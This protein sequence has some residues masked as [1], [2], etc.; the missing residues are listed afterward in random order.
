M[1]S[2][3]IIK[4]ELINQKNLLEQKGFVVEVQ[5]NNPSPTEI[6]TAINN[7]EADFTKANA[8][9]EDVMSGKTFFAQTGELK[10]GTL[11]MSQGQGSNDLALAMITSVGSQEIIIPED[12]KYTAIR[13]YAYHAQTAL[14][15]NLFYKHNLTIPNNITTIGASCFNSCKLTGKVTVPASVTKIGM[16]AFRYC[17]MEEVELS[18]ENLTS[19]TYVCSHNPNL[20]KAV[21]NA[22]IPQL[23]SYSFAEC[24]SL[25][26]VHLPSTLT[27]ISS[28]A[29][30]KCSGL[31]FIKFNNPTPCV[32][33][34]NLFH[35]A[36]NVVF[37]VPY[38]SYDSYLNATNFQYLERAQYGFGEFLAGTTF[39]TSITGYS[40]T[41]H[42]SL[43]EAKDATNPITVCQSNGTYYA[44]FTATK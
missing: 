40:I 25:E 9:P 34:A 42:S 39:P 12:A 2:L 15:D 30:N 22:P 10:T 27:S 3:D 26:E 20:K 14:S 37:V 18:C 24:T 36:T 13:D 19:A 44:A 8:T 17:T 32:V 6:T 16:S 43:D 31:K 33:P 5:N 23:M 21:I 1:N 28:N 4:Q 11:E 41:W 35:Y 7:I 29:F 38:Q